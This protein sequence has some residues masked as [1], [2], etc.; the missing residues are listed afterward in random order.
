MSEIYKDVS[1]LVSVDSQPATAG[2]IAYYLSNDT[3]CKCALT[4]ITWEIDVVD[5]ETRPSK[6]KKL[7]TKDTVY[8]TVFHGI[9]VPEP[10]GTG[11]RIR[12]YSTSIFV[13]ADNDQALQNACSEIQTAFYC[14]ERNGGGAFITGGVTYHRVLECGVD[15]RGRA[16]GSITLSLQSRVE[17]KS[18]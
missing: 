7:R 16:S 8:V 10:L 1:V 15:A 6:R 2:A 18:V 5:D 17:E 3:T 12:R 9:D 14:W 4:G 13:Q 11:Y